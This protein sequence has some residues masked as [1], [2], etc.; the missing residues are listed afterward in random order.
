MLRTRLLVGFPLAGLM[1]GVLF[2]DGLFAP[3]YPILLALMATL[4]VAATHE[5]LSL[6]DPPR[7]PAAWLAY[8]APL[9]VLLSNWLPPLWAVLRPGEM[10]PGTPWGVI[11]GAFV[12]AVL[13]AFVREVARYDGT[14]QPLNRVA[15]TVLMVAYLAILPCFL[16]QLRVG[17]PGTP[18]AVARSGW[19]LAL[20]VFVPKGADIGAYFAGRLFGRTRVTPVLSPKKTLEG[21]AGGLVFGT[22]VAVGFVALA[23]A[24]TLAGGWWAVVG[25]GLTVG[26]AGTLGDLAESLVKRDCRTKDASQAVPGFGGVLD[27]VDSIVFAA[28]VAW[29]WL[30]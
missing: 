3:W 25:F 15:L 20:A 24:G 7:R 11:L 18:E 30:R 16:V 5:F 14:G 6:L 12:V 29:W 21:F 4:T 2:V 10:P 27:V 19:A 13:G 9:A 8:S 28:P 23:P 17:G 22:L 26:L 1:I